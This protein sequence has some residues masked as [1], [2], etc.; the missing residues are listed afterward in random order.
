MIMYPV[1]YSKRDDPVFNVYVMTAR[2]TGLHPVAGNDA[3]SPKWSPDGQ[4]IAF[5][6][7][8]AI[9]VVNAD[10]RGQRR[11]IPRPGRPAFSLHENWLAD[12]APDPG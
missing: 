3:Q 11:L 6:R 5:T 1:H 10:G 12:W 4:T 7:H 2:G 9:W 8:P